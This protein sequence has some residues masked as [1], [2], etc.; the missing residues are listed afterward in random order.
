MPSTPRASLSDFVGACVAITKTTL[1]RVSFRCTRNKK[2]VGNLEFQTFLIKFSL[3]CR[4][5][6]GAVYVSKIHFHTLKEYKF[7]FHS[8]DQRQVRFEIA[9]SCL[10]A[11][12]SRCVSCRRR[13]T[14]FAQL[15]PNFV[16]MSRVFSSRVGIC[17]NAHSSALL[18]EH[19]RCPR[20]RFCF[21][22]LYFFRRKTNMERNLCRQGSDRS[23]HQSSK[24]KSFVDRREVHLSCIRCRHSNPH[25]TQTE[26]AA[27]QTNK[28][29]RCH[30]PIYGDE[31]NE[32]QTTRHNASTMALV[33][34]N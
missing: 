18:L 20:R 27:L 7:Q 11:S 31:G 22:H 34:R 33:P 30:L 25:D 10:C 8:A 4:K 21:L 13:G 5:F 1:F 19:S 24:D 28:V 3:V 26:K 17:E 29:R 12:D 6:R 15:R 9:R 32:S 2:K 14:L 16:R 23:R